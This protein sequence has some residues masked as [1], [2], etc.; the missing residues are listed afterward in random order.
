MWNGEGDRKLKVQAEL[1]DVMTNKAYEETGDGAGGL[2][3]KSERE[4]ELSAETF[5]DENTMND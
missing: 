3:P 1:K 5:S 4:V 2:A